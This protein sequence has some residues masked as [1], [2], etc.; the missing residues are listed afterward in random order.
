MARRP[1]IRTPQANLVAKK[2]PRRDVI[3]RRRWRTAV[4]AKR[5]MLE[6]LLAVVL[7]YLVLT[8]TESLADLP[9]T[10]E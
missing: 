9:L 8:H 7:L 3:R 2:M 10:S 6:V 4:A 5:I 1:G